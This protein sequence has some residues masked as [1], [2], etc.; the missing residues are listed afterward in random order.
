MKP[1]DVVVGVS[2]SYRHPSVVRAIAQ[3]GAKL[4]DTR[5]AKEFAEA[6][7][8][9][10][11]VSLVVLTRLAVTY[12]ILPVDEIRAIVRLAHDR[13]PLVYVDDAGGAR[14]GPAVRS[15]AH[16]PARRRPRRHRPRQV[17]HGRAAPGRHGG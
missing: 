14:V 5:G 15:A 16:A 1:G 11:S 6:M 12:E 8:R 7:E 3:A 10:S 2:A 9:E 17:R 13:G 4:V